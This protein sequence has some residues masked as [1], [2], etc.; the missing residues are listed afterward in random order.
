MRW[1]LWMAVA[2]ICFGPPGASAQDSTARADL[3]G[4]LPQD[5]R[6]RVE[7]AGDSNALLFPVVVAKGQTLSGL[8]FRNLGAYTP[9]IRS[10]LLAD[11]PGLVDPSRIFEGETLLFRRSADRRGLAPEKQVAMALHQAVVTFASGAGEVQRADG[12]RDTLGADMFLLPGDVVRAR[13]GAM[14]EL[15]VDN[16]SI[17][18]LRGP[19]RMTLLA[20]QSPDSGESRPSTR[21]RL[22]AGTLWAKVQKWA[23]PLVHFE[24]IL[25]NAIAGVHGTVFEAIA[26]DDGTSLVRVHE[27][28]V[29][30]KSTRHPESEVSVRADQEVSTDRRGTVS[31]PRPKRTRPGAWENF[32]RGRDQEIESGATIAGESPRTGAAGNPATQRREIT[33]PGQTP[34]EA[35][36]KQPVPAEPVQSPRNRPKATPVR[37]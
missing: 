17:L 23:G 16:Q 22:L 33:A 6:T 36:S 14:V 20:V 21:V 12:K 29:S 26:N 30:V 8:S 37:P 9:A 28:V 4:N 31:R 11:N 25:P 19:A 7:S 18:R 13:A 27:G 3:R 24:V 15:I 2:T 32:N 5:V 1:L 35:Q 10:A 34:P